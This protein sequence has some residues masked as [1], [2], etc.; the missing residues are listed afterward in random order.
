MN[1]LAERGRGA[2]RAHTPGKRS[3]ARGFSLVE[4][5][6]TIVLAGIVFAA[7]VPVFVGAQ[8]KASGD[9]MRNTALNLAQDRVEKIRQLPFDQACDASQIASQLGS[10]GPPTAVLRRSSSASPTPRCRVVGPRLRT[11]R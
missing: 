3:Q 7:M 1:S 9:Q 10:S 2:P 6:V 11:P 8:Q 5:M 4:L